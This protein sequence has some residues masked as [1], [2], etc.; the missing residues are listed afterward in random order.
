MSLTLTALTGPDAPVLAAIHAQSLESAWSTDDFLTFLQTPCY[1]GWLAVMDDQPVGF[2]LV[3]QLA[4]DAE[5][6]TFVVRPEWRRQ[7]IGH[8]LLQ[9]FLSSCQGQIN[10]IFLEVDRGNSPAIQLY[11]SFGFKQIAVRPHYYSHLTGAPTDALVMRLI[12]T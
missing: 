4:P 8:Q 6:L 12:L 5:I 2:V 11:T 1:G 3:S 7:H 9:H 10:A